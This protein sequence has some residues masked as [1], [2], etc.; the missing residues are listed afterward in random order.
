MKHLI[1]I[2]EVVGTLEQTQGPCEACATA[3]AWYDEEANRY[4]RK[5]YRKPFYV[6]EEV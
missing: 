4:L 2:N 3:N 5:S 6:P 1:E